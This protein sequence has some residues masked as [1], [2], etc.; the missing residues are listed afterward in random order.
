MQGLEKKHLRL[1][2]KEHQLSMYQTLCLL[3]SEVDVHQF[4][5]QMSQLKFIT[6]WESKEPIDQFILG[7]SMESCI[8]HAIMKRDVT[9]GGHSNA[10]VGYFQ[11]RS[12]G[13]MGAPERVQSAHVI[14][15]IL[16]K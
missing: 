16:I 2:S 10:C 4:H 9:A 6:Y 15:N 12:M 11:F 1:V 3:E 7:E 5:T 13:I 14:P 8:V